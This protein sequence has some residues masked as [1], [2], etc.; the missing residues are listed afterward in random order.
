MTLFDY[1]WYIRLSLESY[2]F[3]DCEQAAQMLLSI[4]N[5][6]TSGGDDS[7]TDELAAVQAMLTSPLFQQCVTI[8]ES[9][10]AVREEVR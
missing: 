3:T 5:R 1:A 9:L 4:Q 7:L 2:L 8:Q 6:L 10:E